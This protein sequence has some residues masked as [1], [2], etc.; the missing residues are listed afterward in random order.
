MH[1]TSA[2]LDQLVA[3]EFEKASA[4]NNGRSAVAVLNDGRLRHTLITLLVGSTLNDHEKPE[5][6]TLQV[7]RGSI[8]VNWAGESRSIAHGAL[9]VLPDAMHNV[10]ATEDSAF[11]LTSLVG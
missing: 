11:L 6:A 10:V 1:V 8:V 2:E 3:R 7:L 9:F 5:A 4:S